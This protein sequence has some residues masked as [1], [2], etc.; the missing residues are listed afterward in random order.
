MDHP[1]LLEMKGISKEFPGVKALDNVNLTVRAG[2]VHALM[3]E[4]RR[5]VHPDE[6]SVRDL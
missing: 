4:R 5:Q 6:V 1:V 2:T 3:G